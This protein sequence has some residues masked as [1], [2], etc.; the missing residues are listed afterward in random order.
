MG[1]HLER[2]QKHSGESPGTSEWLWRVS[3]TLRHFLR[4]TKIANENFHFSFFSPPDPTT[5]KPKRLHFPSKPRAQRTT[6]ARKQSFEY[7]HLA[8]IWNRLHMKLVSSPNGSIFDQLPDICAEVLDAKFSLSAILLFERE[9]NLLLY[10]SLWLYVYTLL[11][12]YSIKKQSRTRF[13][14]KLQTYILQDKM[15][16][17]VFLA[18]IWNV[19]RSGRESLQ[20]P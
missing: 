7:K 5:C 14:A 19:P 4:P 2:V 8:E 17:V 11:T 18:S 9:V 1:V 15:Q 20:A 6:V 12:F 3:W 10:E 13:L 16:N